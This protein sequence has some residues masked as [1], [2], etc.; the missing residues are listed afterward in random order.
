MYV[1][2]GYQDFSSPKY[3]YDR[4]TLFDLVLN[5]DDGSEDLLELVVG[6]GQ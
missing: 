3:A 2:K 6:L 1:C 4:S 5:G